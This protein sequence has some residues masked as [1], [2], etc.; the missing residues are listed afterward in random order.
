MY[1]LLQISVY[2]ILT[3]SLVITLRIVVTCVICNGC[4][5]EKLCDHSFTHMAAF[6][7]DYRIS[8]C[9]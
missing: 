5:W 4:H 1:K 9:I 2:T 3:A 6:M 8:A 7:I